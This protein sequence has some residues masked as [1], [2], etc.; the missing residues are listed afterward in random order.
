MAQPKLGPFVAPW[1][2]R[3]PDEIAV[4]LLA[5]LAGAVLGATLLHH[6]RRHTR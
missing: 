2:A 1:D 4:F 5:G 6:Y 3:H